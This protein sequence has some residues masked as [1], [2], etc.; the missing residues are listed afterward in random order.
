M[1]GNIAKFEDS[2][3]HDLNWV[4]ERLLIQEL[5]VVAP[6]R[7]GVYRLAFV[8]GL[9]RED[10]DVFL[11]NRF[12]SSEQG[13]SII[14]LRSL[15]KFDRRESCLL[16]A[17]AGRGDAVTTHETALFLSHRSRKLF[18]ELFVRYG[19]AARIS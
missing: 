17:L 4:E 1:L 9:A 18:A 3:R 10:V 5:A 19:Y 12:R 16:D 2:L 14:D 11:W 13:R 6:G 7:S 15:V 8:D